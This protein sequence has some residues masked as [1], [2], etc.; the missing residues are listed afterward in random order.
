MKYYYYVW[1]KNYM[2][3]S[4]VMKTND[5]YFD[6]N[7]VINAYNDKITILNYKMISKKEYDSFLK[8]INGGGNNDQR[9]RG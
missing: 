2:V 7:T 6:F 4:A 8:T 9:C 3:S 1:M 5:N